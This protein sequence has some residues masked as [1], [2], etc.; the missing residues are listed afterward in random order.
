MSFGISSFLL[1][2]EITINRMVDTSSAINPP[3]MPKGTEISNSSRAKLIT[4]LTTTAVMAPFREALFQF[5]PMATTG[6]RA[7][8]T[9]R[10]GGR[11]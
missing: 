4:R 10:A 9:G 8:A 5:N 2:S 3:L 11:S 7:A 1:N 6:T